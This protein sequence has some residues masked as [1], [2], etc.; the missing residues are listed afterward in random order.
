MSCISPS[1]IHT[2]HKSIKSNLDDS[3]NRIIDNVKDCFISSLYSPIFMICI[4]YTL[5]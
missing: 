3:M 1:H 5:Q 4:H 2:N